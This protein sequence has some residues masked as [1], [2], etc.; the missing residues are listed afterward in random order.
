MSQEEPE[1][2]EPEFLGWLLLRQLKEQSDDQISRSKFLK[3]CCITD[4]RLLEVHEYEVG[5]PRYWYMYGELTNE[6]EFSGRFY[7]APQAIGWDG[8]QY[9]PKPM[10]VEEFEVSEEGL[11]LIP[12]AVRWAVREFGRENVDVIKKHQYEQHAENEFIQAYSELRW[13][14]STIDLGEQRRL[15]NYGT[16]GES[17]EDYLKRQLD[18]MMAMYPEEEERYGEMKTLYL[19]WDDTVRLMVEQSVEYS[20]IAEF[21]DEFITTLSKAVLRFAHNQSISEERLMD[22]EEDAA[23]KIAEFTTQLREV[24][25]DLLR[26][27][28]RS[29]ELDSV[30][31]AYSQTVEEQ[32]EQ[33]L[34][35][36]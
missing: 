20:R 3:L 21:L 26:D 22:W 24:R 25:T 31:D 15:P 32:I 18:E 23:E 7:N 13:L 5:L 28:S 1:F 8:Q 19:R 6:H 27:R 35:R 2:G 34:A 30:S 36:E 10:H 11:E 9:I 4:R 29:T 12:K 17:N 33:L 16:R 14:L